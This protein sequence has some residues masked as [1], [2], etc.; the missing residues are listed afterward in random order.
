MYPVM[1]GNGASRLPKTEPHVEASSSSSLGRTVGAACAQ[2]LAVVVV[3]KLVDMAIDAFVT[4]RRERQQQ[5][6][7]GRREEPVG[8]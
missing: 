2:A 7:R 4:R 6:Q 1:N 8:V 5:P 3:A